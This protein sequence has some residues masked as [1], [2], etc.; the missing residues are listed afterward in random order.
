MRT[1]DFLYNNCVFC[2]SNL[3]YDKSVFFHNTTIGTTPYNRLYCDKDWHS[4]EKH[5]LVLY[6]DRNK[7][8]YEIAFQFM[9]YGLVICKD[10]KI[11]HLRDKNL[12]TIHIINNLYIEYKHDKE[13]LLNQLKMIKTFL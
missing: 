6:F 8:L 4:I 12:N 11:I 3:V 9:D 10:I 2:E 13:Y 7:N 1:T 5:Y